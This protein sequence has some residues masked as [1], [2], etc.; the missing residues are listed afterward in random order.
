MGTA[1]Y[2]RGSQILLDRFSD[3]L[4]IGID[5]TTKDMMFTLKSVRCIGC[6]G[7]SPVATVGD[8]VYGKLQ[9]KDIPGILNKYY[10]EVKVVDDGDGKTKEEVIKVIETQDDEEPSYA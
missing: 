3:L 1:C 6:C 8:D 4:D 9:V 2:V 10:E 7:L 5:G